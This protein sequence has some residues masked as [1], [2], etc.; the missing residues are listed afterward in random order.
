LWLALLWRLNLKEISGFF[1][2]PTK[3]QAHVTLRR[4]RNVYA[5]GEKHHPR[6]SKGERPSIER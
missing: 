1:L 2:I 5:L 3:A 4:A 6:V